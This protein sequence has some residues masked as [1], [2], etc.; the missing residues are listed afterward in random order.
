M[1]VAEEGESGS[2]TPDVEEEFDDSDLDPPV[3]GPLGCVSLSCCC[4]YHPPPG[5]ATAKIE[6]A[7]CEVPDCVE[8]RLALVSKGRKPATDAEGAMV[9]KTFDK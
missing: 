7:A 6:P 9:A 3:L 4:I 2:P 1:F 5:C 8:C